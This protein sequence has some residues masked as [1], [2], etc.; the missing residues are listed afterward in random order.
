MP[1][2][3]RLAAFYCI[4]RLPAQ[5]MR[6]GAQIDEWR[7]ITMA[8]FRR[9]RCRRRAYSMKK[10]PSTLRSYNRCASSNISW[11]RALVFSTV[12]LSMHLKYSR[13][14]ARHYRHRRRY[15]RRWP[16]QEAWRW[17]V[18]LHISHCVA[19]YRHSQ[20][21]INNITMENAVKFR[22]YFVKEIDSCHLCWMAHYGIE[23]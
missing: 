4:A 21:P 16:G 19:M 14:E 20:M 5:E 15:C 8:Y 3:E 17:H 2:R 6:V 22:H 23:I 10:L 11:E 1:G 13:P 9:S 18:W 12:A 7:F